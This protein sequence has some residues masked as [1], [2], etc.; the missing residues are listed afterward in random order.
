M[1]KRRKHNV[2][3]KLI[4]SCS[5]KTCSVSGAVYLVVKLAKISLMISIEQAKKGKSACYELKF[6]WSSSFQSQF[7]SVI[8]FDSFCAISRNGTDRDLF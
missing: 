7:V 6:L 3:L 2:N 5:K 8:K 1:K 4:I